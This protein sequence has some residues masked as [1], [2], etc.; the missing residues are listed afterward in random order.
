[1]KRVFKA[2]QFDQICLSNK[3]SP[4]D[5]IKDLPASSIDSD[6]NSKPKYSKKR[7]NKRLSTQYQPTFLL[8]NGVQRYPKNKQHGT[9]NPTDINGLEIELMKKIRSSPNLN[10]NQ[11]SNINSHIKYLEQQNDG[12]GSKSEFNVLKTNDLK[13][14][15]GAKHMKLKTFNSV[16]TNL[17]IALNLL[18]STNILGQ[19]TNHQ[20]CL[21]SENCCFCLLHSFQIRLIIKPLIQ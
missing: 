10:E 16:N 18:R 11:M 17:N 20:K 6:I 4:L 2:H 8:P 9:R 5:G 3:Y 14:K 21:Q 7:V 19:F 1:M 12:L 13:L 15:G